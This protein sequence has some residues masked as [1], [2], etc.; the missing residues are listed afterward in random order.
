[1]PR[2]QKALAL[3]L[4]EYEEYKADLASSPLST[5]AGVSY[6]RLLNNVRSGLRDAFSREELLIF[7]VKLKMLSFLE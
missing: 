1:M 7:A 6:I 3:P 5:L 2:W 4:D